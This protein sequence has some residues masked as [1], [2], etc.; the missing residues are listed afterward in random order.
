MLPRTLGCPIP[1]G[2]P[3]GLASVP[4][5]VL[6]LWLPLLLLLELLVLLLLLLALLAALARCWALRSFFSR[7]AM[8]AGVMVLGLS[9]TSLTSALANKAEVGLA[10]VSS[11]SFLWAAARAASLRWSFSGLDAHKPSVRGFWTESPVSSVSVKEPHNIPALSNNAD[12]GKDLGSSLPC[13]EDCL[14]P[15]LS[16]CFVRR[17][18]FFSTAIHK[19]RECVQQVCRLLLLWTCYRVR[20]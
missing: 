20:V 16:S 10:L 4:F 17:R 11:N 14:F 19:I 5:L 1:P 18:T 2:T 9:V 13:A 8:A 6:L 3:T 15:I 7:S 12:P